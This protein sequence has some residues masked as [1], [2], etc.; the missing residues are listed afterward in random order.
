MKSALKL[1]STNLGSKK[2]EN[3]SLNIYSNLTE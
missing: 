2:V 3:R 1:K